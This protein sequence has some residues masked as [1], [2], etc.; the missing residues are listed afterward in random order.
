MLQTVDRL[1]R[2]LEIA[3]EE[4]ISIRCEWLGGVQ[5]GLA[6]VGRTPMLFVDESMSVTDQFE[7]VRESLSLLDWSE[8]EWWDEI[9][10]L[11]ELGNT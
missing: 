4:G 10:Q 7:Q 2:L 3:T 6:R 5:G 11:L 1:E 8:S 9:S